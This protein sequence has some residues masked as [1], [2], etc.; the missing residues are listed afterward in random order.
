MASDAEIAEAIDRLIA[1]PD[2]ERGHAVRGMTAPM[3]REFYARWIAWAHGG[4][5]M[6][7]GDWR[8]WLML[9]GRGL[10]QDAGGGGMGA[11]RG[12]R[13]SRTGADRAGRR[14]RRTRRGG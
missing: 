9:A 4:Q 8:I 7:P 5:T 6:P 11:R 14:R 3:R 1:L 13:T 2:E 12:R 10:R